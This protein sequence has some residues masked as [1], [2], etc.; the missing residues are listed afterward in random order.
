MRRFDVV[1]DRK[2]PD[3]NSIGGE[4]WVNGDFICYTLELPWR[5]NQKNVSCIPPGSYRGFIRYDKPDGWRIQLMGVSG[6]S[7][8]QIHVG[9][10]P[11]D[12]LGCVLVGTTHGPNFVGHSK[13]AYENLKAAFYGDLRGVSGPIS[14]PDRDIRVE[15][16]GILSTPAGTY[17]K[18]SG[19]I[20]TA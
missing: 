13:D 20:T 5:W 10:Y 16:K 4:L 14:C 9:N 18:P 3:T 15:F 2:R 11:R 6:R 17:P 7:G 1:I 8:V 12:I 19:S